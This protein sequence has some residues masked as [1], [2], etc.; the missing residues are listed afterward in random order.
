MQETK[1]QPEL[2]ITILENP[3]VVGGKYGSYSS[4]FLKNTKGD[5]FALIDR[6]I[7]EIIEE[8]TIV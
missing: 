8:G 5:L 6:K 2:P 7:E 3:V 4:D 1:K